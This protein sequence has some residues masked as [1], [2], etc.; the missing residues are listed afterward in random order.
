MNLN[1]IWWYKCHDMTFFALKSI[2]YSSYQLVGCLFC[3]TS[4]LPLSMRCGLLFG[5]VWFQCLVW[6]GGCFCQLFNLR[7]HSCGQG[8]IEGSYDFFPDAN[9][10]VLIVNYFVSF[11]LLWDLFWECSWLPAWVGVGVSHFGQEQIREERYKQG[12]DIFKKI[13]HGRSS[14]DV[15]LNKLHIL[16]I[17]A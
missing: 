16:Y 3:R 12:E 1:V 7:L 6:F 8:L 11:P 10:L 4:R 9:F 15:S 14:F 5:M 13:K 2:I 17:I